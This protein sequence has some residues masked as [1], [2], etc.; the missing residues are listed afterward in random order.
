MMIFKASFVFK[1]LVSDVPFKPWIPAG[2]F[3]L[4]TYENK[5]GGF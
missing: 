1:S 4:E 5:K 3:N 2:F